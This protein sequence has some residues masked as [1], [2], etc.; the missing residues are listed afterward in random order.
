MEGQVREGEKGGRYTLKQ[1]VLPVTI[2]AETKT[3]NKIY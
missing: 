1:P 3:R 2:E